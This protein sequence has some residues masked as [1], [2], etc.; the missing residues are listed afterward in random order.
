M[1]GIIEQMRERDQKRMETSRGA[2][3]TPAATETAAWEITDGIVNLYAI[4][5]LG[6]S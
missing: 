4:L 5:S 3:A 6:L 1:S 2:K